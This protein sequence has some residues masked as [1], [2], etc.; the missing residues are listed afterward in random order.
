MDTEALIDELVDRWEVMRDRGTT[1]TIEELCAGRPELAAE[2]RRRIA[3]LQRVNSV[4]GVDVCEPGTER[5]DGGG[6]ASDVAASRWRLPE[7]ARAT[8]VYRLQGHHDHGGLGVILTARHEELDRTVALKRIRPDRLRDAARRRF[9]REATLTAGL[10]HPGI[11]PIYGVGQDEGGPF[12]TMPFIRG[13][14]LQEAIDAF[15][16]DEPLRRDPG[17]RGLR[18]R[19]LLQQFV[20]A[21]NTVAYAHDQR[22]IHRDLKPSN[23]ML[24][25][26]GETLVMDWGLAKRLGVDGAADEAEGDLASPGPS[27]EDLTAAGE[28]LG[29]PWYM[30]PEQARGEP[31]GPAGDI[32]SLGLVLYAILTGRSAYGE[33]SERGPDRL[34][35]VREAAI[36]PP[37][38]RDARLPGAL[39]AIC[40][41]ALAGRREDRYATARALADDVTKWLADEPVAAWREPVSTRVRRWVQRYRTP[42]T[43][44]A[45]VLLLSLVGLA[46]FASVLAGKNQE[47]DRQRRRAEAREDLAIAAV[48][49]FRDAVAADPAL[50]NRPE[51]GA[52]RKGLLEEPLAFFRTIRDQVQAD[53]DTRPEALGKLAGASFELAMTSREIGSMPDAIRGLS[54]PLAILERLATDHPAVP[55]WRRRLAVS[56]HN[57]SSLLLDTA[58]VAGALKMN[59]KALAILERLVREHPTVASFRADLASGHYLRGRL[60]YMSGDSAEWLEEQKRVVELWKRADAVGPGVVEYRREVAAGYDHLATALK[61]TGH[62]AEALTSYRQGLEVIERLAHAHPADGPVQAERAKIHYNF[63]VLMCELGDNAAALSSVR[64]AVEIHER[65]VREYPTVTEYQSR[66]ALD[67]GNLGIL[68]YDTDRPAEVLKP[69]EQALEINERLAREH[70]SVHAYQSGLGI[71]LHNLAAAV[72][73]QGQWQEA[74]KYLERAIKHQRVALAAMPDFPDYRQALRADLRVLGEVHRAL[75]QPA[76]AIRV[77]RELAGLARGDP[78]ELYDVACALALNVPLLRGAPRSELAAE[79]VETLK[80]AIAA[81]WNDTARTGR[82]PDLLP[83]HDRDE[84]RRLVAELYDRGFPVDPFAR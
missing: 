28:V 78:S 20:T 39:E 10:Q 37:R 25:P 58:D 76:D 17:R 63:G 72:I 70:P 14:T 45:A 36:V 5:A 41:K 42:V 51:L 24:G 66:L 69:F 2:L 60:R 43:S 15:H 56:Y 34:D 73:D 48:K 57:L 35:A 26:Y 44:L 84:F 22:V 61:V 65:L 21:C 40:L 68:L 9:L 53:R 54:E 6:G 38:R 74:R 71:S 82:D 49:R 32:Y 52:L 62:P 29:T 50:K 47:L 8:A 19:G 1:P 79:A 55:E 11:V 31:A 18:L 81:G 16:D 77:T 3:A 30:S 13:Q 80:R 46:G 59:Q 23:I 83:L 75:D 27:P 64:R 7:V 12:Y 67:Y 33:S 4:L